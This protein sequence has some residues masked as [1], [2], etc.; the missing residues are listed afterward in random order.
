MTGPR[1]IVICL[2]AALSFVNAQ[3][4]VP[5]PRPVPPVP[6][7]PR[8]NIRSDTQMV[9]VPVTVNDKLNRPVSGLEREN[10]R[11]YEDNVEQPIAQFAMDDEPVAV[12]LIFDT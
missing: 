5:Q 3:G 4:P 7:G 6:D 2:V 1:W 12:G 9:L 11:V 10:F 8:T